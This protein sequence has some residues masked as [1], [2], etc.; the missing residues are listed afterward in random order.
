MTEQIKLCRDCKHCEPD[1]FLIFK[2]YDI[3]KCKSKVAVNPVTGKGGA[4]CGVERVG[5]CGREAK[6]W[7]AK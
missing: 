4:Y 1:V 5:D 2:S 3:A 7:E 6:Y